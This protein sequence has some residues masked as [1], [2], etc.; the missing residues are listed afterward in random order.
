V[1]NG[2][3]RI[4][5]CL[6]AAWSV[7]GPARPVL[8]VEPR[9][10]LWAL[11][12]AGLALGVLWAW[13]FA[14]TWRLFGEAQGLRIV[15]ALAVLSFDLIVSGRLW[16]ATVEVL[17]GFFGRFV[18]RSDA[19]RTALVRSFLAA[20]FVLGG[21]ALLLAL[22]RG[23]AWWPSDWRWHL[24]W[25]YPRPIFRPL[26]LM[27]LWTC[28]GIVLASGVGGPSSEIRDDEDAA[29]MLIGKAR[30]RH[31]FGSFLLAVALTAIYCSKEG[32]LAIGVVVGLAVFVVVYSAAALLAFVRKGQTPSGLLTCGFLARSTFVLAWLIVARVVHAW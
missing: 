31:I 24:R 13:V 27:P 8:S 20:L 32:N 22:P 29:S 23:I 15:P 30:L 6:L 12:A 25:M 10:V 1:R 2:P 28:W 14:C 17:S 4:L 7:F 18:S 11:P 3:L 26:V 21:F 16:V 19:D 9:D 5:R